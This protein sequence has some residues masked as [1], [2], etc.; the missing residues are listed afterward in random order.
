MI[1]LIVGLLLYGGGVASNF[2]FHF[3]HQN[4]DGKVGYARE[5]FVEVLCLLSGLILF[6]IHFA[7]I[8]IIGYPKWISNKS[9]LKILFWLS[10]LAAGLILSVLP[11]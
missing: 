6:I 3:Y 7:R 2:I 1:L 9:A 4:Y 11:P 10:F 8:W 5:A